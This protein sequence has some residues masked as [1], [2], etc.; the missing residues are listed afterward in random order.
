MIRFFENIFFFTLLLIELPSFIPPFLSIS[1]HAFAKIIFFCLFFYQILFNKEIKSIL[2]KHKVIVSL[3]LLFFASQSASILNVLSVSIF[4]QK[5]QNIFFSSIIFFL[6]MFYLNKNNIVKKFIP[7]LMLS[8]VINSL[9]QLVIYFFPLHFLKFGYWFIHQ[10]QMDLINY[11]LKR[12]RIYFEDYGEILIPIFFY[13]LRR[14]ERIHRKIILF[15]YIFLQG[16]FTFISTFRTKLLMYLFAFFSSLIFFRKHFIVLMLIFLFSFYSF[17]KLQVSFFNFS[18]LQRVLDEDF[19]DYSTVVTRIERW[20]KTINI[21]R[22]FPVFGVGLGHYYHYLNWH[23]QRNFSLFPLE[24][25]HFEL[26]AQYPHNIFFSTLAE[27][28]FIGL[29]SLVLLIFYF[30]KKDFYILRSKNQLA[31]SFIISFWTL[32]VFA[33]FNPSINITY[34]MLFWTI[35]VAIE[36]DS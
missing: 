20:Q 30:A 16:F 26:S 7:I 32:F 13:F 1:T 2:L 34:Q 10:G 27:T 31:K 22:S 11:N 8:F 14:A 24:R 23:E 28:G 15:F 9:F 29:I 18:I 25:K 21:G 6:S 33:L 17:Y 5:Y 36:V 4:L 12:F 19:R 3:Y 35:R